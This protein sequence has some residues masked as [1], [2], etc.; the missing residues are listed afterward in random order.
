MEK[1]ELIVRKISRA[2]SRKGKNSDRVLMM[3]SSGNF[4]HPLPD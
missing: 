4:S 2:S 1:L 3:V